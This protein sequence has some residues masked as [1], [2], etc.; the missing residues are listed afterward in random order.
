MGIKERQKIIMEKG[1]SNITRWIGSTTSVTLHTILFILAFVIP[2]IGIVSFERMLLVLTTIVSLEAI[3]LSIFIQ[4]SI[5]M[6]NQ[7]IELIQGDIEELGEDIEELGEDIEEI[8]EDIEELGEDLEEIGEDIEEIQ[9][10]VDEIQED[11]DEI[12]GETKEDQYNDNKETEIL[13]T[14]QATLIEL[15]KEIEFLKHNNK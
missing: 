5:N 14:I 4:M 10:D 13:L 7:N 12:Q 6:N 3:Y 8:G 9:K 11:V 1:A 15:Q 2:Y